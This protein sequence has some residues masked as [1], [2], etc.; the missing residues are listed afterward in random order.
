MYSQKSSIRVELTALS[1]H[2]REVLAP[3]TSKTDDWVPR[4][5]TSEE[6]A[7]QRF[8]FV[9]KGSDYCL[10]FDLKS[11]LSEGSLQWSSILCAVLVRWPFS[12]KTTQV[13]QTFPCASMIRLGW[14]I[15][16]KTARMP[17]RGIEITWGENMLVSL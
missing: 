4:D 2:F 13:C 1:E 10:R 14:F 5:N 8:M 11:S 12:A 9:S 15:A 17:S 3:Q 6:G 7:D 16:H